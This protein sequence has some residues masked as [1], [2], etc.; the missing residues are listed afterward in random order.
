[1]SRPE[2]DINE[3]WAIKPFMW[4]IIA[5]ERHLFDRLKDAFTGV[6]TNETVCVSNLVTQVAEI[7]DLSGA[8]I[9]E[10]RKITEEYR[11]L[12]ESAKPEE[13]EESVAE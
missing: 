2:S 13:E 5:A 7:A 11:Q 3:D 8:E 6:I 9:R 1:M 12:W 10:L 4:E